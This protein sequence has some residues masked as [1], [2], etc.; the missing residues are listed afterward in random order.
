MRSTSEIPPV[1]V[2]QLMSELLDA[3]RQHDLEPSWE[4]ASE[5]GPGQARDSHPP[6]RIKAL[7]Q[8]RLPASG[9]GT[10]EA[11]RQAEAKAEAAIQIANI[12]LSTCQ[13]LSERL[14]RLEELKAEELPL[15][16][17]PVAQWLTSHPE[18]VAKYTGQQIAVHPTDG[19]IASGAD[20]RSVYEQVLARGYDLNDVVFDGVDNNYVAKP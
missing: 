12:A 13:H 3:D 6:T 8:G 11:A 2:S 4:Q 7:E 10:A 5:W 15:E 20:F 1:I 17:D 14:A 19:I 9:A 16:L 18:E